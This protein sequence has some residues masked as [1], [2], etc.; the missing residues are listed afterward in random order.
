[1]SDNKTYCDT[2]SV[3]WVILA[4]C[5]LGFII[6]FMS[7]ASW[8]CWAMHKEAVKAGVGFWQSDENGNSHFLYKEVP[9]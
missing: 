7:G 5:I 9:K 1:M 6:G 4:M 8:K 2:H 3:L